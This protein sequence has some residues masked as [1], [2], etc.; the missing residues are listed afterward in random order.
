MSTRVAAKVPS[1][2]RGASPRVQVS[3]MQRARLLSAAIV[4]VEELG[5]SGASVAHITARAR[6]SRRTF[7]DLFE[8]REDCL[9]AVLD[10]VVE[11]VE[12]ELTDVHLSELA[13]RERVRAGLWTIL[14]FLDREP[15]LARVCVAQALQ[16]GPR[17]LAR[18]EQILARVAGV[19]DEGRNGESGRACPPLTA[20]GLVGAVFSIVYARLTRPE[21]KPLANLMGELMGMLVLPYAGPAIARREQDRSVPPVPAAVAS[22]SGTENVRIEQDPLRE[23]PMRL[24]YRTARVLE[25]IAER[26]GVSNRVVGELAGVPDQGQ[27]SKLL[28]RLERLGLAANT[29][30]G[31]SKGESNAWSLTTLGE[32]VTAHLSADGSRSAA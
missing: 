9:L 24:T 7:Y 32:R 20:E 1:R 3:E 30:D 14:C 6:V 25:T 13:W 10:E 15:V 29:G 22:V 28:A 17:V 18:R 27:I 5:W 16:G 26:P 11:R 2:R 31:H 23:V 8:N 4:T 21:R 19:L 12:R